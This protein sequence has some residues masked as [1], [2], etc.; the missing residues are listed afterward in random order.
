MT[1]LIPIEMGE[2][3]SLGDLRPTRAE[4]SSR[5]SGYLEVTLNHP[6]TATFKNALSVKQK[7]IL[8]RGFMTM[9][10]HIGAKNYDH[11]YEACMDGVIHLHGW[12]EIPHSPCIP[13]ILIN[14]IVKV[15]LKGL[16]KKYSNWFECNY[17][18]EWQRYRCPSVCVQY[19]DIETGIEKFKTYMRKNPV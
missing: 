11:V 19:R 16:T 8:H 12:I 7:Q 13:K 6:R 15:W 10:N 17:K 3:L 1:D 18:D 4:S 2:G 9:V 5:P 14:D